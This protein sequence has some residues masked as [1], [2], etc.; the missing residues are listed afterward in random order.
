LLI[1]CLLEAYMVVNFRTHRISRDTRK[2]IQTPTSNLKKY[3]YIFLEITLL[4]QIDLL[5]IHIYLYL[6]PFLWCIKRGTLFLNFTVPISDIC[7][8]YFLNFILKNKCLQIR[9]IYYMKIFLLVLV[10][11]RFYFL[12]P[13]FFKKK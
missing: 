4:Q 13:L 6:L 11:Y 5:L 7:I 1:W 12:Y 3:I 9:N 2:L 8:S 10:D